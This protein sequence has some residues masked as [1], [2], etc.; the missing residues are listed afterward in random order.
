MAHLLEIGEGAWTRLVINRPAARNALNTALLADLAATL[1]RLATAP[2]CR[3]VLIQGA[4]GNFAAGADIAE[5]ADKTTAEAATDP[6]KAYWATIRAFP[7]PLVAAVEGFALG[8]GLELA[9]MADLLVAGPIPP[10][11]E[12]PLP[13][14]RGTGNLFA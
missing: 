8:G 6:R 12:I 4:E 1:R 9:L 5:I 14:T 13:A 3:A 10:E 11:L 2:D 7:K